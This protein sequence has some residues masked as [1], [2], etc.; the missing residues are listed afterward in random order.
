MT[1][2]EWIEDQY[3]FA[4]LVEQLR[5]EPLYAVDTEFHRER[6]YYPR[7]ALVQIAWSTGIALIDPTRVGLGPLQP[8]LEGSGLAILHAAQQD[9]EVLARACGTVPVRMWDTQIAASFLGYTTP[10]LVTLV[11][12][13]LGHMLPKGDRLTDWF[14]RPLTDDQKSYAASAKSPEAWAS[15]RETWLQLSEA[16]YQAKLRTDAGGS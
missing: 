3:R 1:G 6:T 4:S 16:D 14:R 15:F 7:L 11:H 13:E 8:V 5:D 2:P 12:G 10:S 9:L